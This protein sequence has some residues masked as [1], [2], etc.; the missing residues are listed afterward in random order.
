M[1]TD[2]AH[3]GMKVRQEYRLPERRGMVGKVVGRYGGEEYAV[4]EVHFSDRL[5]WL[6]WPE[7]LKEVTSPVRGVIR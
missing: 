6:L 4:V 7:D 3:L 2:V 1:S 5:R